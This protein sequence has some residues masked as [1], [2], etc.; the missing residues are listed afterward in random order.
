MGRK[1]RGGR[2]G[3]GPARLDAAQQAKLS[4]AIAA[5]QRGDVAG[6]AAV[7]REILSVHRRCFDALNLLG[8]AE[9]QQG[10]PEAGCAL[11]EEAIAVDPTQ[12]NARI[13]LSRVLLD[14]G[15]PAAALAASTEAVRLAPDSAQ[16]WFNYGNAQ[17]AL[18]DA[19]GAAQSYQRSLATRPGDADVLNNLGSALR[20]QRRHTEALA[21]LHACLAVAPRHPGAH[22]NLG[23]VYAALGREAEALASYDTALALAPTLKETLNNR[24]N[25]LMRMKRFPVAEAAFSTLAALDPAYP[26]VHG[27]L[28]QARLQCGDWR[29]HGVLTERI[30]ADVP[31]GRRSD[32]PFSFLCVSGSPAAQL[33]CARTYTADQYPGSAPDAGRRRRRDGRLRVAYVSGDFGEHPVS[34]LLTGVLE[35]HDRATVD[36]YAYAWNRRDEGPLRRRLE[37]AVEHFVDV[38]DRSDDEIAALM[39]DRD[40]DIAV[41][42]TGHTLGNRTGIFARRAAPV[43]VSFLGLPATMGA[44]YIDYLIADRVLI[45]EAQRPHYAE[46]VVWMPECYQPGDRSCPPAPAPAREA[47]GLGVR[48]PVLATFNSAAKLNPAMFDIWMRLLVR[49]PDA[50]LW[51]VASHP[52]VETNL[53]REAT[54]RGVDP[55]RLVFAPRSTYAE[56]LGRYAHAD[57]FLDSLPFNAGATAGDAL[58]MGTPVLTCIGDSFASRM[59]A[60]LLTTLGLDELIAPSLADYERRAD[61]LLTHPDTLADLRT[62]LAT[63][64]MQHAFFDVRRYCRHL[65]SA[66]HLMAA[67]LAAGR[68]PT[69]LVVP[70]QDDTGTGRAAVFGS[71]NHPTTGHTP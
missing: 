30:T 23:L 17:L 68:P 60:S 4:A 20:E 9:I 3:P 15:R 56:Y 37:A 49:H 12:A 66:F 50:R 48:G 16:A 19:P 8:A 58:W 61:D 42:L 36:V 1:P 41:D 53:R 38:T 70:L 69:P 52:I 39:R 10:R 13:N 46:N 64:R 51:L 59:A 2:N 28:L 22:N 34:Y 45:P 5:H 32:F 14:L 29:D 24:G 27:N 6:A 21:A 11:I 44:D 26:Y 65:E 35:A 62:R 63:L 43:Q 47:L 33:A 55:A 7:Y 18:G 40:I 54:A 25:L 31:A 57:L 67:R 71:E